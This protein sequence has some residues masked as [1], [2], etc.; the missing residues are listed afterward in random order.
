MGIA[1]TV[2]RSGHFVTILVA[3]DAVRKL[4]GLA[5][6]ESLAERVLEAATGAHGVLSVYGDSFHG[7][8][9]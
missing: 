2:L 1:F 3:D 5:A 8:G 9:T 6:M 4:P 7:P